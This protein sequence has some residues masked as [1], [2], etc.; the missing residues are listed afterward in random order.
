MKQTHFG[1]ISAVSIVIANMIG[2]GVFTGLGY[3]LLTIQDFAAIIALWVIGGLLSLCGA[4][5]YC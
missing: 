2:T 4:F 1:P 3:Q 5:V